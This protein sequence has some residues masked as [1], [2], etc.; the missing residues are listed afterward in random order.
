M[1]IGSPGDVGGSSYSPSGQTGSS[2][3]G[4][5]LPRQS[6]V[7]EVDCMEGVRESYVAKGF[8][9]EVIHTIQAA[10]RPSTMGAYRG[11]WSVFARW[12]S[13][14]SVDPFRADV[15]VVLQFLNDMLLEGKAFNTIKSYTSALSAVRGSIDGF[16]FATHPDI[17]VFLKGALRCNPPVKKLVPCW[18][19]EVVLHYLSS[20]VFE[21]PERVSLSNWTLKT[22]FLVAITSVSRCSELQALDIRPE[23]SRFRRKSVSLR[24]NP[25][26][27]P[28]V[29]KPDYVNRLINIEAFHPDPR[30]NSQRSLQKICPV[31]AL[32]VY[33]EKSQPF[34]KPGCHQLFVS[35]KPG[36]EGS[37]I[38]KSRIA[39]WL[40]S[41][42]SKAYSFQGLDAPQGVR[43]HSTRAV[44]ASLAFEKGMSVFDVCRA[45]TWSDG[46]VFAKHYRLDS[47]PQGTSLSQVVLS[48]H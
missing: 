23:L 29:L 13:G 14:R 45:A 5:H 4:G 18:D 2:P 17:A 34:R 44:G 39:S 48:R 31:R 42:I 7:L 1:D 22:V 3:S 10:R 37:P 27:L 16:S 32:N 26:F 40:V 46:L 28:K 12:C 47:V 11:Q 9:E 8:S 15:A 33:L 24:T 35:F 6:S 38:S 19:L 43:A 25:V 41:T 21:P 30:N 20:N 36:S